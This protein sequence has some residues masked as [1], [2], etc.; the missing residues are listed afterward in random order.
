VHC[1]VTGG[2]VSADGHSWCPERANYLAPTAALANLVRGK[3]RAALAR[4]RPDLII[5]EAVWC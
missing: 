4:R 3:L 2:G 1:L 5:P